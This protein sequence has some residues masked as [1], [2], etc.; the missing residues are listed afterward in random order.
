MKLNPPKQITFWIA[1]A[2]AAVGVVVY[3]LYFVERGNVP[4]LQS[5]AFFLVLVSF[6]LLYL[7]LN[8]KGL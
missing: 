4:Y 6:V 3:V 8:V 1:V 7:G 2:I 5:L